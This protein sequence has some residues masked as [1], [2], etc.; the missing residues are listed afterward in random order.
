MSHILTYIELSESGE[1][2]SD[3]AT[4]LAAAARLGEP[5]A[6]LVTAT[7]LGA[8]VVAELGRLGAQRIHV[9]V[10]AEAH[11]VLAEPALDALGGAIDELEPRAVLTAN[12]V[13]GREIAARLAVR[14]AGALLADV[15]DVRD[16]A[17]VVVATHSV[18]G[19]T[20]VVEAHVE[21]GLPILT[22]RRGAPF[23]PPPPVDTVVA[24]VTLGLTRRSAASIDAVTERVPSGRPELRGAERVVSGGRGVGSAENFALV[25]RL[26][27]TIDA[28][29][30]ASRAAV[31][32]GYAPQS[33][34]VGQTGALV[35]PRLYVALGISGAVQHR[36]GMQTA[37]TIVAIDTDP[38]AP[39]FDI[40][41]FGIV[42]DVSVVVPRLIEALGSRDE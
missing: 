32:A 19:G 38:D 42:G 36:A 26:A 8:P 35:S 13:D 15:V 16:D 22:V 10:S 41:D 30:G 37:G 6:V 3:A 31:D 27:D 34:Q 29:V 7:P 5:V 21:G 11:T 12:S 39:L 33:A 9:A 23:P 20:Y 4:L 14:H 24:E 2:T 40:A 28:A 25:E 1:P 17:G 18:F